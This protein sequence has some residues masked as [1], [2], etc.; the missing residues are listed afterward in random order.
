MWAM[1]PMFR[2][3]FNRLLPLGAAMDSLTRVELSAIR[4][5]PAIAKIILPREF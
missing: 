5:Q 3:L 2:I 1:I 4:H